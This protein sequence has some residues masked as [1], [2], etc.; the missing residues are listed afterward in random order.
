[1]T[2]SNY[3][4]YVFVNGTRVEQY[5][6]VCP[7]HLIDFAEECNWVNNSIHHCCVEI[8]NKVLIIIYK[9]HIVIYDLVKKEEIVVDEKFEGDCFCLNGI[10]ISVDYFYCRVEAT[11]KGNV[12]EIYTKMN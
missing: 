1:M 4:G 10:R 7:E 11:Y 3:T 8:E 12:Y 9:W 5:E 2:Y 6:N